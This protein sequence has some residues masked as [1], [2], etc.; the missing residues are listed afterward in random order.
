MKVIII[1]GGAAGMF[2]GIMSA[3]GGASVTVFERNERLGR[4]LGI[5]GKGRCN[6]TNLADIPEI[7]GLCIRPTRRIPRMM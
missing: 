6:L 2:A 1:G 4:K 3:A 5:T 7:R